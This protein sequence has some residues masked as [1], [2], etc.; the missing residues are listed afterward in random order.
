MSE[1]QPQGERLRRAVRWVSE[2][3][4]ER[5]D[6]P[7]ML[8]V[9]EATLHFDLTPR[10]GEYLL[11]FYRGAGRGRKPEDPEPSKG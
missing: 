4:R 6:Q 8:L 2:R 7:L 9:S 11:E 1:S 3:L 5:E 10:E